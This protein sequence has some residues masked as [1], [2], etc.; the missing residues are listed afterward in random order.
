VSL[1]CHRRWNP[2]N[3]VC[4]FEV[5]LVTALQTE[6]PQTRVR[7]CYFHFAQS[8][9][10]KVTELGLVTNYRDNSNDGRRLRKIV[11]KTMTIGFLPALIISRTFQVMKF[12]HICLAFS[13]TELFITVT[14]IIKTLFVS[15]NIFLL[16]TIS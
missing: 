5:A 3:A 14:L 16:T 9:W 15:V 8:L 11:Q 7:G 13:E 2:Q 6:L 12:D 4:D 1:K 10:R